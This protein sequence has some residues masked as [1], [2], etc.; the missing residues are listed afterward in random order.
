[1]PQ[2][3]LNLGTPHA[4]AEQPVNKDAAVGTFLFRFALKP[5]F[6]FVVKKWKWILF[7][8]LVSLIVSWFTFYYV[9]NYSNTAWSATA[10]VFHQ[11]RSERIPSFYKPM[12]T[13]SIVQFIKSKAVMSR[14]S[15]RMTDSPY[16]YNRGMLSNSDISMGKGKDNIITITSSASTPESAAAIAN[17]IAEE[18]V[19]EYIKRQNNSIK[20]MIDERAKQ[21]SEIAAELDAIAESKKEFYSPVSGLTPD[22][23]LNKIRAAITG[24]MLK[25]TD[26]KIRKNEVNVQIAEIK[27]TLKTIPE[28]IKAEYFVESNSKDNIEGKELELRAMLQRYTE[29]NPK[30]RVLKDEIEGLK[31]AKAKNGANSE[32]P[33]RV[34]YRKNDIYAN[35]ENKL[36]NL[37]LELTTIEASE[38]QYT[39]EIEQ[40]RQKIANFLGINARYEEI[41]RRENMLFDKQTKLDAGINDLEFLISS[42]VPDLYVFEVASVPW[43][44]NMR[45]AR[46]KIAAVSVVVTLFFVGLLAFFRIA[47]MRLLDSSEFRTALGIDDLGN[48]PNYKKYPEN[49]FNSALHSV[50]KN[51]T[52]VAQGYKTILFARYGD[53]VDYE[54]SIDEFLNLSA[55]Q[56]VESFRLSCLKASENQNNPEEPPAKSNIKDDIGDSLVSVSKSFNT[57]KFYY[58]NDYSLD[59]AEIDLLK[60]DLGVLA[61]H[62]DLII[63]EIASNDKNHYV[64]SQL[65]ALADYVVM[66]A[67][68]DKINKL[69]LYNQIREIKKDSAKKIGGVLSD[70]PTPYFKG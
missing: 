46:A 27:K 63:V 9:G 30:V 40:N 12:G 61:E 11:A 31:I 49:V 37:S 53:V 4:E 62:Y 19:G 17:A 39:F 51:I 1:M 16:V 43:R 42:A 57:G 6:I 64:M 36:M 34:M 25:E 23:E 48:V 3:E 68:F 2:A 59:V 10:K 32:V 55:I 20:V 44:S 14:V 38:K 22:V 65:S 8:F 5:V 60:F 7:V 13:N 70:L 29:D 56:G 45:L 35:L 66:V 54:K 52:S 58:Q 33:S 18:G 15:A 50:Y 67:P 69:E 47:K 28:T 21:K 24:L 26:L 41:V